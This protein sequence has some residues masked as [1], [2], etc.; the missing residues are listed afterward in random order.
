MSTLIEFD[1][2]FRIYGEG[3]AEVRALNGVSFVI[4]RGEFVAVTGPSG[5]GKSTCLNLLGC[6]DRSTGGAYRLLGTDVGQLNPEERALVR[7]KVLGFVFQGF[8]LLPRMS[9][10]E[11]VELPL[12]YHGVGSGERRRR[13]LASLEAVGLANRAGH[14][15]S[16]MSGGQQQRVAIAR[17]LVTNPQVILADEPTG[18]LDSAKKEEIHDL[19]R[20]LNRDNGIT[21]IMVTHDAEGAAAASRV[22]S[23]RDGRIVGDVRTAA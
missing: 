20:K 18:N 11:N 17:A 12:I 5:C 6:L 22:L 23:F 15:P 10:V 14:A 13:A 16:E 3:E 7:R 4:E 1:N 8:Q 2:V 21:I 19:L 9:A